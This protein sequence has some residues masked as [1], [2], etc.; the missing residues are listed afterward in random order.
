MWM[1]TE[2]VQTQ[3]QDGSAIPTS[4]RS[5]KRLKCPRCGEVNFFVRSVDMG[6][7][8]LWFCPLDKCYGSYN[9][10]YTQIAPSNQKPIIRGCR[11]RAKDLIRHI[12]YQDIPKGTEGVVRDTKIDGDAVRGFTKV[13]SQLRLVVTVV[14]Q[15]RGYP[16]IQMVPDI[17]EPV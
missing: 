12:G 5:Q 15:I 10:K 1:Q 2:V 6:P 4:Q 3:V 7:T 9:P 14:W 13:G 16:V 8:G 11:V 17:L